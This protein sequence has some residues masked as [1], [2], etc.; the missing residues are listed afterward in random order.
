MATERKPKVWT[1]E[2]LARIQ[3]ILDRISNA[4]DGVDLDK[5]AAEAG[6]E[7]GAES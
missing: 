5:I 3:A 6:I 1:E 7:E 4:L 2:D